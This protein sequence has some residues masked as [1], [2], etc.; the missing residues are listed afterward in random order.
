MIFFFR[1]VVVCGVCEGVSVSVCVRERERVCVCLSFP[2]VS[3]GQE[4]CAKA[5]K[6]I[7]LK[8]LFVVQTGTKSLS[9]LYTTV[10]GHILAIHSERRS[11]RSAM[12][13]RWA[14]GEQLEQ[15]TL[16]L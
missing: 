2:S 5:C 9:P 3:A 4:R 15:S 10:T 12:V 7:H 16:H 14:R 11:G 6:V 1:E 8:Q 13:V